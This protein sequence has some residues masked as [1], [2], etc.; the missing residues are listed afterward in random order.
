MWLHCS[1]FV[2]C[3]GSLM[4]G[5][6]LCLSKTFDLFAW[7]PWG[8]FHRWGLMLLL[9]RVFYLVL[10][11]PSSGSHLSCSTVLC[12]LFCRLQLYKC[13]FFFACLPF[14]LPSLGFFFVSLSSWLFPC[15]SSGLLSLSLHWIIPCVSCNLEFNS[16]MIFFSFC[17]SLEFTVLCFLFMFVCCCTAVVCEKCGHHEAFF[18]QIQIRSADEPMTTFYRCANLQCNYIWREG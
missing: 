9:G 11:G 2:C 10:Q 15:F 17:F 18:M 12:L 6:W 13:C 5:R 1:S 3:F 4:R 7:R 8:F 16:E 14:P